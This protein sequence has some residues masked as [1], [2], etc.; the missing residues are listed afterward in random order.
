MIKEKTEEDREHGEEAF[1]A[2]FTPTK[3]K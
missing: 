3:T 2:I 1:A